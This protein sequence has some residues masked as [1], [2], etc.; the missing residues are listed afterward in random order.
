MLNVG[1]GN[2][3]AAKSIVGLLE[4]SSLPLKR[5]REKAA[6]ANKLVDATAGRKMRSMLLTDSGYVI[7]SCLAAQTLSERLD[8]GRL[9]YSPSQLE[10]EEGEFV[11]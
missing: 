8:E 11:S 6:M 4:S 10:L 9:E 3:V 7:L 5:F 1:H 2:F